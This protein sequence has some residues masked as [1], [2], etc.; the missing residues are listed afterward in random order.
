MIEDI[1]RDCAVFSRW[2]QSSEY[3]LRPAYIPK[4]SKG[5]VRYT[6]EDKKDILDMWDNG[7]DFEQIARLHQRTPYAIKLILRKW[8]D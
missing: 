5:S 1:F 7:L 2:L 4:Y 3:L 8:L 6:L